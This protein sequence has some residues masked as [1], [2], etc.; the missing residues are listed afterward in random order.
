MFKTK[1]TNINDGLFTTFNHIKETT[2]EF[3]KD[4][5]IIGSFIEGIFTKFNEEYKKDGLANMTLKV[6]LT[7]KKK[8][9]LK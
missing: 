5:C 2:T 6:L 9:K 4:A 8:Q 1:P 3:Y 7:N